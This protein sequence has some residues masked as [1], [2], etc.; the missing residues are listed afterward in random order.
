M[1]HTIPAPIEA[2]GDHYPLSVLALK[3]YRCWGW[4]RAGTQKQSV[5]GMGPGKRRSLSSIGA[6]TQKIS[7]LGI[8]PRIL[9]V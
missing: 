6:G 9:C 5:L 4:T 7:V 2:K 3:K 8:E 1:L